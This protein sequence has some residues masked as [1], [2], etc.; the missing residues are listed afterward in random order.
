MV[1]KSCSP[2]KESRGWDRTSSSLP[3]ATELCSAWSPA[4]WT[5]LAAKPAFKHMCPPPTRK[6]QLA[7]RGDGVPPSDDSRSSQEV[8]P[9]Q[10]VG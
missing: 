8:R 1:L 10:Q 2:A 6:G 4:H 5:L 7:F 3:Q 9:T